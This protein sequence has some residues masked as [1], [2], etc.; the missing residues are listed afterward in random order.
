MQID[1]LAVVQYI[2]GNQVNKIKTRAFRY[3]IF[4]CLR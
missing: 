3:E 1:D 4:F 2:T